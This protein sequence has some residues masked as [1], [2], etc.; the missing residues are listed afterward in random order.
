MPLLLEENDR[1]PSQT[2][3]SSMSKL[4]NIGVPIIY[5]S[6]VFAKKVFQN[7]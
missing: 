3:N 1:K 4:L 7:V 6:G 5:R 2:N